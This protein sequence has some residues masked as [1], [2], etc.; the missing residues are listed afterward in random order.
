[1]TSSSPPE[2]L[3]GDGG[4]ALTRPPEPVEVVCPRCGTVYTTELR[5]V[6]DHDPESVG[7]AGAAT[8]ACPECGVAYG[9]EH[10]FGPHV[11]GPHPARRGS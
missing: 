7:A 8:P 4:G 1:M 6:V 10:A 11:V 5:E 9:H 3:E 2:S